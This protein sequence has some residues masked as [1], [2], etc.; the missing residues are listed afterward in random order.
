MLNEN[1][2]RLENNYLFAEIAARVK[3]YKE[4]NP[5]A[6]VS[7]KRRGICVKIPESGS[8]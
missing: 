3:K 6:E 5:A 1:F 8:A 4:Q 7:L 2:A